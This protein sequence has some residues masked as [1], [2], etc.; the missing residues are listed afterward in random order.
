MEDTGVQWVPEA[1][2]CVVGP[3]IC[4]GEVTIFLVICHVLGLFGQ[5]DILC[6]YAYIDV[7]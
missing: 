1:A 7:Y 3:L 2:L 5:S 6:Q 4:C